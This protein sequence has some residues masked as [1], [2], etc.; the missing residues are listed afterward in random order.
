MIIGHVSADPTPPPSSAALVAENAALRAA[1]A[2]ALT[3]IEEL[4]ARL[5][6][7]S[8]NSSKPPSSD[9]LAK[10]SP[11]SLRAKG[12]RKPG[13]QTG[14]RGQTLAQAAVPDEVVR[15]EP[16]ACGGCGRD[17]AE[18]AEAGM[19]ARQVVDLPPVTI[20]V[21]E[22]Q[23]IK[24]R[25]RCGRITAGQAPWA[26]EGPVQYGPRV[27]AIIGYLYVGQ[28][29]SKQRTAATLGELFGTPVS[30]GTVAAM[31]TRC[32]GRLE[33]FVALACQRIAA[34]DLAHFDETGLRVQGRLCWVHS[35]STASWS[36]LTVHDRR[37]TI[38]MD[39]A[40]VLPAFRGIAVHDA[41]APYDTYT[42]ASHALCNAHVLREL[43]AVT[44]Q[45]PDGG[46]CWAVQAS[47]AL[48]AMKRLV[49]TALAVDQTLASLDHDALARQRRWWRSAVTIGEQ[50]THARATKLMATH[51]ALHH[52]LARRLID[53]HDDYLRFTRDPRVP[54][55]N[56]PAEREIRM[57]KL[58]QKVSGC[59]RTLTG[60]EQ[61]CTI[62]SYLATA[63]KHGIHFFDALVN[64]AEGSPWQPATT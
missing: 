33:G 62:R 15:H 56:N 44:D 28:L 54:F 10:P 16:A 8:K 57:I 51:H 11:R 49:D 22:H 5:R 30:S 37:G 61:F 18:A 38:G 45:H 12:R 46:W 21:T 29:L 25:C 14:H 55:D 17:L 48:R 13:G 6:L 59:L 52:A 7:S 3:R 43:Q 60:A 41:W 36:L 20:R 4:E 2:K 23:L 31:A 9:G 58:R 35:A 53:R 39:A 47:T 26:V 40:G 24:R 64:L 42:Q 1:L 27:T 19:E 63:R 34:A 50:Q 32:A